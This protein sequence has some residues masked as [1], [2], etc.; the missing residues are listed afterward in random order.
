MSRGRTTDL[1]VGAVLGLGW[2]RCGRQGSEGVE[3]TGLVG[4][5][6]LLKDGCDME[7]QRSGTD[8]G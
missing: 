2:S 5:A 8:P 7:R 3:N 1:N 4:K 6:R